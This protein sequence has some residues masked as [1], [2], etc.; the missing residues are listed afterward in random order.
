MASVSGNHRGNCH[1]GALGFSFRTA[2][3]VGQWNVRACQCRFCRA[4]G[5]LTTSDPAG[6]LT[7]QVSEAESLQRY[8]FGL[9]TADFL[10]C[11]RCGVYIGA[12]IETARGAFGIINILALTPIPE[13]LPPA[14]AADY[15]SES[16]A[17]RM[18]R[19]EKKWTPVERHKP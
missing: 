5:A 10:L 9:R 8:R 19:R 7:F 1:C 17:E 11:K 3:P 18:D 4:H 12:Q 14:A 2:L 13:E 15:G 16:S 6:R